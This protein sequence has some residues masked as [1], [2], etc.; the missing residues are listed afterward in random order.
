MTNIIEVFNGS[1][2]LY[3]WSDTVQSIL[4]NA[5][6]VCPVENNLKKEMK[7]EKS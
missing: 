4:Q 7:E 3:K 6:T 1:F 2:Y 5:V